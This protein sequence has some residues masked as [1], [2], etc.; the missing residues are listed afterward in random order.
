MLAKDDRMK[1]DPEAYWDERLRRH[2]SDL[3][4][5]GCE[6]R[7]LAFNQFVYR[8]K[9]RTINRA[10]RRLDIDLSTSSILDVGTGV[11]FW[12]DYFLAKGA[13]KITGVDIAPTAIK[14]LKKQYEQSESRSVTLL[15]A[16]VSN[17]DFTSAVESS[18]DLVIAMDV[19][20]HIIEDE[21]F[22]QQSKILPSA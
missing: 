1:F 2:W 22:R 5:V 19:L 18:F 7:S 17:A 4:G 6:G 9:T 11:G 10:L 21:K 20:Y 13:R 8:S 14:L 16:D 3:Q 15:C 12:V